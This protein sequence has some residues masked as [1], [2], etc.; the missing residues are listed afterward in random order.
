MSFI[1]SIVKWNY[2]VVAGI[3]YIVIKEAK[4]LKGLESQGSSKYYSRDP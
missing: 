2:V 3:L 1:Y 4:V